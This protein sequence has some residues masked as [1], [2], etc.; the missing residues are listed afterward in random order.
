M[1]ERFDSGHTLVFHRPEVWQLAQPIG[2]SVGVVYSHPPDALPGLVRVDY[3]SVLINFALLDL[4]AHAA[5]YLR[6]DPAGPDIAFLGVCA[7]TTGSNNGQ[8]W[9]AQLSL[10][11]YC[12]SEDF[13]IRLLGGSSGTA[14]SAI[15]GTVCIS[16]AMAMPEALYS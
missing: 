5:L 8:M 6:T 15:T 1:T 4:S 12:A 9:T 3:A 14:S 7:S 2:H 10:P 11:F 13:Q 16:T